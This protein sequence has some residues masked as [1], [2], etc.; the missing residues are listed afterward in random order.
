MTERDGN[1][2][3]GPTSVPDRWAKL[4]MFLFSA[5]L[6]CAGIPIYIH[7][8]SFVST[9]LGL[10]LSIIA[11][12]LLGIRALDFL[13]DPLL[14]LIID[15]FPRWRTLFSFVATAGLALGFLLVFTFRFQDGV[16]LWLIAGLVVLMTSHSLGTL[17]VY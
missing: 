15:K 9:E 2:A 16:I 5:L 12:I 14:G 4:Q 7:L 3:P 17:L 8:P 13:Q 1:T 10:S 11:A 6:G